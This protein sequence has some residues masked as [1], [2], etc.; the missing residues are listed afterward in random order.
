[1]PVEDPLGAAARVDDRAE[2]PREPGHLQRKLPVVLVE[3]ELTALGARSGRGFR[4]VDGDRDAVALVNY[5]LGAAAQH[6]SGARRAPDASARKD[7]LGAF[8]AEWAR[9]DDPLV[10]E[11]AALLPE[12]DDRA[13]FLAGVDIFLRGISG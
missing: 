4:V 2:L 10:R 8:A 11:S 3:I 1:M 12:H 5:V 9:D 6:A 7:Y 13:Q